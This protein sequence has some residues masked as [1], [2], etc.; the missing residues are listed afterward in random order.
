MAAK[1]AGQAEG[2]TNLASPI[3]IIR[4][5]TSVSLICLYGVSPPLINCHILTAND[6]TSDLPEK[7]LLLTLS[8][9]SH[10]SGKYSFFSGS[11]K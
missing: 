1:G 9:A 4:S 10:R 6:H 5:R 7:F 11:D 2:M 8:G 3:A